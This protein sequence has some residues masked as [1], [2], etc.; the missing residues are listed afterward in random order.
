M[1][2]PKVRE[3][4][5]LEALQGVFCRHGFEGASLSLIADAT[6][7]QRA[8][9]YHRFPD[10]KAGMAVAVLERVLATFG[11]T[12]LAPLSKPGDPAA[13]VR[14]TAK[15]LGEFYAGGKRSCLLETLS[16][17]AP[18]PAVRAAVQRALSAAID[19]F[20]AVA[21]EC[22]ASPAE[23]ARRAEQALVEV[24]GALVV[25]RVSGDIKPFER[26]LKALPERITGD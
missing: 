10:G 1:P 15:Q 23:A 9:L 21:R 3:D 11:S 26:V 18:A 14:Q 13:R 20:A 12:V 16:L 2:H 8:S 22:G 4:S 19:A 5:L 17:G 25:A 6:G 7:L 24:Q